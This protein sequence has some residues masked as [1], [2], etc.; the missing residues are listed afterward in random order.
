MRACRLIKQRTRQSRERD[1]VS[2]R[3][4]LGGEHGEMEA[5]G[6][7]LSTRC[8]DGHVDSPRPIPQQSPEPRSGRVTCNGSRA[9]G[10]HG[11]HTSPL[12][13]ETEAPDCVDATMDPTQAS[14]TRCVGDRLARIAEFSQLSR[15]HDPVLPLRQPGERLVRLT[16]VRHN[17]TKVKSAQTPP[18]SSARLEPIQA[19]CHSPQALRISFLLTNSSA[20]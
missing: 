1:G 17:P 19:L 7:T 18:R 4:V 11:R 13:R 15:R 16:F 5:K 20:P 3:L 6:M 12:P 10:E 14:S 2:K 8:G 9:T